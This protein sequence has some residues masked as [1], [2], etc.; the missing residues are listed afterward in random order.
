MISFYALCLY[1]VQKKHIYHRQQLLS[2][3]ISSLYLHRAYPELGY[4]MEDSEEN[5]ELAENKE[6][7]EEEEEG[8]HKLVKKKGLGVKKEEHEEEKCEQKLRHHMD[9][10]IKDQ[11]IQIL[12][13]RAELAV[14]D[15]NP[16]DAA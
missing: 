2:T 4:V 16:K 1:F 7:N 15:S 6:Q 5:Q 10:L 11:D 8:K 14:K 9:E 3:L 13:K 12:S